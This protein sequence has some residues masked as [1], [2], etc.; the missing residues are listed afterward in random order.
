MNDIK[1]D[2]K[3]E[4]YSSGY[5]NKALRKQGLKIRVIYTLAFIIALY[6]LYISFRVGSLASL[7]LMIV[8][9]AGRSYGEVLTN[10]K[11]IRVHDEQLDWINFKKEMNKFKDYPKLRMLDYI[12]CPLD[13]ALMYFIAIGVDEGIIERLKNEMNNRDIYDNLRLNNRNW[14]RW[15]LTWLGAKTF[16][17]RIRRSFNGTNRRSRV[18]VSTGSRGSRGGGRGGSGSGDGGAGGF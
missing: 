10:Q 7:V 13:S 1:R 9:I 8:S 12:G 17:Q 16:N 14:L 15:Y 4:I 6:T 3:N 18:T 5:Y 2:M 11:T